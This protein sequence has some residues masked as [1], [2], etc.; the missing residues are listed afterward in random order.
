M[1]QWVPKPKR[2]PH[3]SAPLSAS[4]TEAIATSPSMV[5]RHAFLPFITYEKKWR[6]FKKGEKREP[7]VRPIK[8]ASSTDANIFSYYRDLLSRP[9]EQILVEREIADCV[10]AYRKI[11]VEPGK[12]QGKCNI[13][14]TNEVFDLVRLMKRCCVVALDVKAFFESLDHDRLKQVWCQLLG[15]TRLPED[16][17]AVF[18]Q[19]TRQPTVSRDVAFERLGYSKRDK[20]GV[21]RY[22]V[23][24]D[25]IPQKLCSNGRFR[26]EV[27]KRDKGKLIIPNPYSFGIPQ[28]APLSDLLANVYLLE[29]DATM[30]AYVKRKGGHYR[31]YSDDILIIVPGDGRAGRGAREFAERLMR[32]Q[33]SRLEIKREKTST[34]CFALSGGQLTC[35]NV[36]S[37]KNTQG[38][39]YLGF[40]FDGRNIYIRNSTISNL[41]RKIR[42]ACWHEAQELV[43]RYP[44][45]TKH[46]IM[47]KHFDVLFRRFA[48]VPDFERHRDCRKWTFWTYIRKST[49]VFGKRGHCIYRQLGRTESLARS[50]LEKD[51]EGAL[52]CRKLRHA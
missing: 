26:E 36:G 30:S 44:G 13:H 42:S 25:E 27:A 12:P 1:D 15:K 22:V 52:T 5:A 18:K 35:R 51:I 45:K 32:R 14:F 19:L 50:W 9:Y 40:R 29:F 46:F 28:G 7:K 10:I 34:A 8:F 33:G 4:K 47:E 39:E 37:L 38:L 2:Y 48:R 43:A 23:A 21:L 49:A 41:Q 24:R 20:K 6:R 3:F 31:R 11:P 17:Y 16:H